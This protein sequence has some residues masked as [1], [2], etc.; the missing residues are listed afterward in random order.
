[1]TLYDWC[2]Q[3]DSNLL[4]EWHSE[5]NIPLTPVDV[6][7][8]SGRKVWWKGSCGHEWLAAVHSRTSGTGC[9]ICRGKQVLVG[10]N[11]LATTFPK[12]AEQW[13]P[14][15]N[16]PLT[17][18]D[19][20]RGY[21]KKKIWW[22]CAS[23]HEW[24]ATVASRTGYNLGCP[25]CSGRYA[26]AGET[27]LLTVNPEIAKEW[28]YAKNGDLTPDKVKSGT[29]EKVWWI[30]PHGHSYKASVHSRTNAK[31]GCPTCSKELSVSFPE[32]AIA[33]YLLQSGLQIEE[34]YHA[35][36][37]EK[38][39]LDI[40]IPSLRLGVE[41]DGQAWHRSGRKDMNKDLLCF[42]NGVGLL[43]IREP[44]CPRVEGIGP[45]YTLPDTRIESLNSAI[46]FVFEVLHDEYGIVPSEDL[47]IDV[48]ADRIK[49]YE[50]M[51]FHVKSNS[52][53]TKHP[54]LCLEWNYA[55]NGAIKPDTVAAGSSKKFWWKCSV[56]SH[57]WSATASA[58][59]NGLGCP[60]CAGQKV[61]TGYNDL[62]TLYPELA[63]EWNYE[64]NLSLRPEEVRPRT[65]RKAW[66]KCRTCAHEW[67]AEIK[68]RVSGNGCP[69]CGAEKRKNSKA[70]PK[71]GKSM[72]ERYPEFV[73]EWHPTKNDPNTAFDVHPGSHKSAWWRCS[74]CGHEF[75]RGIATHIRSR[76][77]P[78]CKEI[79]PKQSEG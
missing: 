38:R 75:E 10:Y 3:N 5:K 63:S 37:L 40:Y 45:C 17:P 42:Q 25:F 15:K 11:D 70:I 29:H 50:L 58:R 79:I 7:S 76:K 69:Q 27:D 28:D 71:Q 18:Q 23:G 21:N 72:A 35:E 59:S 57:E 14:T 22:K 4:E 56:C 73:A 20:T 26:I 2:M 61:R 74:K 24:E 16:A 49:I 9:P 34:S 53:A 66:W 30:C 43:R 77:C 48:V 67:E 68:S 39:E 46:E 55:R 51:A 54:Q 19:V 64:R 31:S 32:K 44:E 8:K 13:H 36:W 52:L 12:F 47:K 62:L 41:Y 33:Y 78:A 6:S 65:H 60:V 1:M